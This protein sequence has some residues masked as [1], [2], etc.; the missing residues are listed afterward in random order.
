MSRRENRRRQDL[1]VESLEGRALL[2]GLGIDRPPGAGAATLAR[3]HEPKLSFNA[4][5]ESAVLKALLGGAGHE[6]LALA[7]K[8][9]KNPLGVV[10][11]ISSGTL[12]QY[13]VPGLAIKQINLQ[14]GYT[15]LPHDAL[16]LNIG[17]AVVLKGKKIELGAI[18]RGPFTTTPFGTDVVFAIN[19]G[20]G[21]RLGPYYASRPGITPDALVTV[22]VG[23]NGQG[24]S[25]TYTDLTTGTTQPISSPVISVS[26]PTVRILLNTSQLPSEGFAL[27]HYTFAVWTETQPNAPIQDVG[28]FVPEDSM[29]P[30]GVETTV[31]PT[32]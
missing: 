1:R 10:A 11:G 23:P 22:A 8:E 30:I 19:R 31:K 24:N 25:A 29:I 13:D 2:S 26:G 32:L 5:G 21:A 28:S 16:A 3:L 6:F 27:K 17:G 15:G 7:L 18:V 4:A 12:T 14:S 9:V 20:A